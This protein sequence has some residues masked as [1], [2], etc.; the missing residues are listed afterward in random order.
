MENLRKKKETEIQN[1]MEGQSIN[2]EQAKDK[3]SELIDEM[4]IK[5]KTEELL[6]TELKIYERNMQELTNSIKRSNMR[7]LG[8]KEGEQV[9][10][11]GICNIFN[12]IITKGFCNI[13]NKIITENFPNLEKTMPIQVHEASSTPNRLD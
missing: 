1:T 12:K 3:I 2:L 5:G 13:F 6:V 7:I 10:A 8:I 9:Q 4:V 11:K